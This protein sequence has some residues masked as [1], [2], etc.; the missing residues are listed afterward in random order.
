MRYYWLCLSDFY[1]TRYL[2]QKHRTDNYAAGGT[3]AWVVLSWRRCLKV[4][5]T[6]KTLFLPYTTRNVLLNDK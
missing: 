1:L 4:I 3:L 2:T 6:D 5:Q